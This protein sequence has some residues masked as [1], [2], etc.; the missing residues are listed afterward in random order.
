[1]RHSLCY[2]VFYWSLDILNS[3]AEESSL[4]Q[5]QSAFRFFS[6][7]FIGQDLWTQTS[8]LLL[9]R[10]RF[11][12]CFTN[13]HNLYSWIICHIWAFLFSCTLLITA[14]FW[15]KMPGK[16]FPK[17]GKLDSYKFK[18]IVS[19]RKNVFLLDSREEKHQEDFRVESKHWST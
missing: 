17:H 14:M 2:L 10:W 11:Y 3:W 13:P 12:H 7:N 5:P 19:W 4:T 18:R 15:V 1:M 9:E 16:L 6:F 8:D